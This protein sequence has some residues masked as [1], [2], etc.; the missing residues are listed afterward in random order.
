MIRGDQVLGMAGLALL[1]AGAGR[2]FDEVEGRRA[3]LTAILAALGDEPYAVI[4]WEA[5]R[6][7]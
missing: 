6:E 7:W 5:E 2:R 3:E 4:V 1:R